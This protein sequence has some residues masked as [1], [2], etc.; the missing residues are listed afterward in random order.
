MRLTVALLKILPHFPRA[1]ELR[2]HGYI[3]HFTC[4]NRHHK[5]MVVVVTIHVFIHS[6]KLH[7]IDNLLY[8]CYMLL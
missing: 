4:S 2:W 7:T 8:D 5:P 3:N 1:S 6:D